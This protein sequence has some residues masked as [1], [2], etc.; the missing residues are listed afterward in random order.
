MQTQVSDAEGVSADEKLLPCVE[1]AFFA[2][3]ATLSLMLLY[4]IRHATAQDRCLGLPDPSR[5]LVDKGIKQC[6]KLAEFFKKQRLKPQLLLTSPLVRAEQTAMLLQQHA[7]W[8]EP[9][10]QAWLIIDTLPQVQYKALTQL[11]QQGLESVCCVGHEPDISALLALLL[12]SEAE[13][14][15]IKKASVTALELRPDQAI[16]LWSLPVALL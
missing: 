10:K 11:M 6:Q 5:Y 14:F 4:L 1:C 16:L 12:G 13:H 9:Q 8:P 7:D 15:L 2:I 3:E